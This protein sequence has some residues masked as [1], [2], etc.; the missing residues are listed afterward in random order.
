MTKSVVFGVVALLAM[1]ASAPAY[2]YAL[3]DGTGLWSI[4]PADW[5]ADMLWGNCFDTVSGYETIDSIS[6]AF[7]P[8]VPLGREVT[9]V[10][11]DDPDDDYDP[12]NAIPLAV[13]TGT[14]VEAEPNEFITFDIADTDVSGVF[15]V[16]AWMFLAQHEHGPRLDDSTQSGRSWAFWFPVGQVDIDHLGSSPYYYNMSD[17]PFD[18]T[19]MVRA[20]AVPEPASLLLLLVGGALVVARRPR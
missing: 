14:T 10:L 2:E 15:F 4:G 1:C 6:I 13:T 18:A 16:A 7:A 9:A 12:S 20:Q 11:F 17:T 5:D 8:D 19:W 3:D